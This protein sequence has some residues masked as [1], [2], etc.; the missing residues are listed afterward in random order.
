MSRQVCPTFVPVMTGLKRPNPP[1]RVDTP[2]HHPRIL[3]S[4]QN[5]VK[6]D[7]LGVALTLVT[8]NPSLTLPDATIHELA[9]KLRMRGQP[10]RAALITARLDKSASSAVSLLARSHS[11][12]AV[13]GQPPFVSDNVS[14]RVD[15]L[16][17]ARR[18]ADAV[19]LVN[20]PEAYVSSNTLQAVVRAAANAGQIRTA[21]YVIQTVFPSRGVPPTAA[22]YAY[23]VDACGRAGNVQRALHLLEGADFSL[24]L[25]AEQTEIFAR[26]VDACVRCH[27]PSAADRVLQRMKAAN[28]PRS[29][30]VY[31]SLLTGFSRDLSLDHSLRILND[32]RL[33]GFSTRTVAI[34]NALIMGSSRAGRVRDAFRIY[35]NMR[36]SQHARPNLDTYNA[37]LACCAK[38]ALPDKAFE[39]LRIMTDEDGIPPSPK[40]YNWVV[41]ACA[42]VGD[43]DRA[44]QVTR[45]MQ[46]EGIRL[47]VVTNNNLLEACCNAGRIE[48]AFGMVKDMIQRQGVA[49]NSHTYNTLIRGCGRWGLI[50]PALRLLVSMQTAGVAPTLITYSVAIDACARAGGAVAVDKAFE[51]LHE[52]E[53]AGLEPNVVTYN[54]LIHACARGRRADLA[55]EVRDRMI[56]A[57]V[58]VDIVT[59]CSLVDACGRAGEVGKAF[60]IIEELRRDFEY[61]RPTV[62]VYNALIH[63]CS[64]AGDLQRMEDAL[65]DMRS[66]KLR[67]NVVTFS[68]L[69]SAY[70][71]DGKIDKALAFLEEM[72]TVGLQPNRM[73]F[74]SLIAAY[75]RMGE[76]DKAISMLE[77][78]RN[79]ALPDEELF[80]SGIVAAIGGGQKDLAVQ[81]KQEMSRAGFSV[82]TVLNRMMQKVGDVE[83]T[84]M[85]LQAMLSAME[86]LKI[87]PQRAALESLVATYANEADVDAAFNVL[88]DMDRL[89]YPPNL[90]TYKKLILACS[91]SGTKEDIARGQALFDKLR[92]RLRDGD[93]RLQSHNWRELYEALLRMVLKLSVS[94]D[95]E[96]PKIAVLKKMAEDC[97]DEHARDV[98][99]RVCPR[100]VDKVWGRRAVGH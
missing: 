72:R 49:P 48:R 47:N 65:H 50:D 18:F 3:E 27:A 29:E 21:E 82:P 53:Q 77:E 52:M 12:A 39:V 41:V 92:S 17:A 57:K 99:E 43:V 80:T 60:S 30:R 16:L 51:L 71:A 40:T 88:P 76:V 36:S 1:P 56:K 55:F 81:L 20:N 14:K 98:A 11:K 59:L 4:I 34:Y 26:L 15:A 24:L 90:Q 96:D 31:V 23:F 64:K 9:A 93:K 38:A 44:L 58:A 83:R 13:G 70:A 5:A 87:R 54:S 25:P 6:R 73:T 2:G 35:N 42:R 68:T 28:I 32:M 84:G 62:P 61:L 89:R 85:E 91:L 67:P 94:A 33:D 10:H 66:L 63:A 46:S 69:I 22:S 37:L 78:A 100:V 95:E 79:C 7:D 8:D 97:G 74:T 75:G 19:S 45:R 86:A